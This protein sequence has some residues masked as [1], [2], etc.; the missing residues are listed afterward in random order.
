MTLKEKFKIV[1]NQKT[2][3]LAT[4]F[5]NFETLHAVVSAAKE[6]NR[7]LILQLTKSS[8]NYMGLRQAVNMARIEADEQGVEVWIHLD[9]GDCFEL[10]ESCIKAGFDSVM[11]D[12]SEQPIDKNIKTTKAVVDFAHSN[13][14]CV[15]AELG[16]V[17]KLGQS[18]TKNGF[19]DPLEA[20]FF[21]NETRVDSL[22][23]AIGSA[24][25]FYTQ[26]PQLDLDLLYRINE[27]VGIPL[28]LHGASGI[29]HDDLRAAVDRGICKVNLATEIKNAF[30]K[31]I[32]SDLFESEEIDLRLVFPPAIESVKQLV[33]EKLKVIS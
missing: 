28:V 15:E 11:I 12:A 3:L 21:V 20:Q 5:Y 13:G 2:S 9:H 14:V 27:L 18:K 31:K 16:Y 19:T 1:K 17:A 32:K 30:M 6:V 8:I 22:A 7:P 29:P 25:G 26:K 23:V 4:N 24:H 10:A 33:M